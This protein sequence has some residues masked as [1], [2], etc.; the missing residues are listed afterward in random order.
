VIVPQ[1][2]PSSRGVPAP[3]G[4]GLSVGAHVQW[5]GQAW[6]ITADHSHPQLGHFFRLED[7]AGGYDLVHVNGSDG[8]IEPLEPIG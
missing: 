5:R 1:T 7:G 8:H 2:P 3:A 6:I 4:A